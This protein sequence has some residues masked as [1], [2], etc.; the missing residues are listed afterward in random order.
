[1]NIQD[2]LKIAAVIFFQLILQLM[3]LMLRFIVFGFTLFRHIQ[4]IQTDFKSRP[5]KVLR[6]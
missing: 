1:M 6:E 3:G 5:L 4:L 2:L